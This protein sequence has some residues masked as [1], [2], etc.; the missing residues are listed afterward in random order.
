[1]FRPQGRRGLG[2]LAVGVLDVLRFI[3]NDGGVSELAVVFDI[4]AQQRI[5]CDDEVSRG[6]AA[7]FLRSF[8]AFDH[9]DFEIRRPAQSLGIPIENER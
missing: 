3:Q 6:N 4:D 9:D 8:W 7:D 5:T 2:I 1:M